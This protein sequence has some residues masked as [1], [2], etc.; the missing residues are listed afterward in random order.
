MKRMT[1]KELMDKAVALAKAAGEYQ[2]AEAILDYYLP[3]NYTVLPLTNYE[4][5]FQAVADYGGSE[6]IFLDCF[7][8]GKFDDSEK[9]S[10]KMGTF[11]TLETDLN[12]M[13][14]MAELGGILNHFLSGYVNSRIRRFTSDELLEKW[15]AN[16]PWVM[17]DKDSCQHV[18][19]NSDTEFTFIEMAQIEPPGAIHPNFEVYADTIDIRDYLEDDD[20]ITLNGILASYGY[21]SVDAIKAE[22]GNM[23]NQIMCECIFEHFG[24]TQ[25]KLLWVCWRKEQARQ[26]IEGYV[27][28]SK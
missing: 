7:I 18:R 23:A 28:K 10:L 9:R 5:D 13:K 1:N 3:E 6:G 24:S 11:K 25:A 8:K 22:Y 2:K 21:E 26:N 16:C 19:K 15:N 20:G 12:A 14:T 27:N 17:T 4:F